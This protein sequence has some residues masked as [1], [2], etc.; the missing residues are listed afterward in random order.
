MAVHWRQLHVKQSID[1]QHPQGPLLCRQPAPW[2]PSGRVHLLSTHR[3]RAV[4]LETA[5]LTAHLRRAPWPPPLFVDDTRQGK[6]QSPSPTCSLASSPPI[7]L[8]IFLRRGG[9][10][11]SHNPSSISTPQP[12]P[13]R[14]IRLPTS[15]GN[16]PPPPPNCPC[17]QIGTAHAW[18]AT[19]ALPATPGVTMACPKLASLPSLSLSPCPCPPRCAAGGYACRCDCANLLKGRERVVLPE[20]G[21]GFC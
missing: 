6:M 13:H 19:P 16:P 14:P 20:G 17:S 10:A 2:V 21:C 11:P 1:A 9:D 5:V 12:P 3:C 18:P 15:P 4:I 7:T 8:L